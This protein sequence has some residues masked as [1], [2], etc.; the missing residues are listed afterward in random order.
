MPFRGEIVWL[1]AERGGRRSGPP[2]T[3]TD[4]DHAATADVSPASLD[5]GSASFVVRVVDRSAWRSD[6]Q[7]DSLAVENEG[8]H[9][10]AEGSIVAVTEGSPPGGMLPCA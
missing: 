5:D 2:A 3:P 1:T 6:V 7:A 10:I 8:V 9:W 4:E